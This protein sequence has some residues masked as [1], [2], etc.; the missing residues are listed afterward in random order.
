[1]ELL[2]ERQTRAFCL[3]PQHRVLF[4]YRNNLGLNTAPVCRA[5]QLPLHCR[6]ER[7]R[8]HPVREVREAP[9]REG[10]DFIQVYS[11]EQN[12]ILRFR[13]K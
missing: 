6:T 3:L 11:P 8:H 12:R 7:D 1:M 5:W 4:T 13:F 9:A 2:L 10:G